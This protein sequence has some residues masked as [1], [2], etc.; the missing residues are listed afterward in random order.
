[1]QWIALLLNLAV[2]SY[3]EVTI[4]LLEFGTFQNYWKS[5]QNRVILI[6]KVRLDA[7]HNLT[8]KFWIWKP[9]SAWR[10]IKNPITKPDPTMRTTPIPSSDLTTRILN[11]IIFR[12]L[13]GRWKWRWKCWWWST[14]TIKRLKVNFNSHYY[15]Y[16]M[17]HISIILTLRSIS[18]VSSEEEVF[19]EDDA[20]D[21]F[22]VQSENEQVCLTWGFY[23]EIKLMSRS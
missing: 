21:F 16:H 22:K 17:S 11:L 12:N 18:P 2:L 20:V 4:H 15:A 7:D 9:K 10:A 5:Y 19:N 3:Q 13:F 6:M 23:V 1:M 14:R 8:N